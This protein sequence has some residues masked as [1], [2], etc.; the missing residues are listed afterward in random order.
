[1]GA[2]KIDLDRL[3]LAGQLAPA[4]RQASKRLV[5]VYDRKRADETG[6][7]V[8]TR[9]TTF[10]VV[11]E[12]AALAAKLEVDV[13]HPEEWCDEYPRCRKRTPKWALVPSGRA[14]RGD[15]PWRCREHRR[16][17]ATCARCGK[18]VSHSSALNAQKKNGRVHCRACAPLAKRLPP[19]ACATCGRPT[20]KMTSTRGRRGARSV[21]CRRCAAMAKQLP[22]I[23]CVD[24]GKAIGKTA[25]TTS[26][27][28]GKPGRCKPCSTREAWRTRSRKK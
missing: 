26:R 3:R 22:A 1:M 27:K 2:E 6:E 16:I 11:Q 5:K 10:G 4:L 7:I 18:R 21:R 12:A 14:A 13:L 23:A 28:T 25:A 19:V 9:E 17:A 20:S 24:C 15:R 8:V